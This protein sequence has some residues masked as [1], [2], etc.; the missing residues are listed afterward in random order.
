[1]FWPTDVPCPL[2]VSCL[3]CLCSI[4]VLSPANILSSICALS[5]T[6]VLFPPVLFTRGLSSIRV[7][8]STPTL[9]VNGVMS[10]TVHRLGL[11]LL[12][13]GIIHLWTVSDW[14]VSKKPLQDVQNKLYLIKITRVSRQAHDISALAVEQLSIYIYPT[15]Q[16][17]TNPNY[18]MARNVARFLQKVVRSITRTCIV[19]LSY[20][21]GTGCQWR[22][23]RFW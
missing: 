20:V 21:K 22:C 15:V 4:H 13:K 14:T 1:M 8:S 17:W 7:L 2:H 6:S 19:A 16:Y 23:C 3:Q 18:F 10:C 12:D 5:P 11:S 9:S